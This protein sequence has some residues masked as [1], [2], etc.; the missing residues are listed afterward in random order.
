MFVTMA[1][2]AATTSEPTAVAPW[3]NQRLVSLDAYRGAI[4]L[5]MASGGLGLKKLAENPQFESPV[6]PVL[7]RQVEHVAWTGH[8][9]WDLIQPAFMFMVG[10]SMPYS[11][12]ARW[13]RGDSYRSL[14]W[15]AL[16]RS[17]VLVG[18]GVLL[19]SNGKQQTNFL[20]TNVLAQ[21]GLGYPWL[22]LLW[23]RRPW[24]QVVVLIAVLSGYGWLTARH[25]IAP[26][27]SWSDLGVTAQD[28]ADGAVFTDHRRPWSKHVNL[29]ADVD[30]VLL[31]WFPRAEPFVADRGGYQTLNFVPSLAT[32]ILGLLAGQLLR[33]EFTA[34]RK[35]VVLIV[36]AV[37][38]F[39]VGLALDQ[40]VLPA[41]KR[42]WTPSWALLSGGWVLA[43]LAAFYAVIDVVGWRRWAFP[44]VVVG[45]NSIVMYLMAQLMK[46]WLVATLKTH[47]GTGLFS[48]S[49]EPFLQS[50]GALLA[51]WLICWWL[52][53]Q[54]LFV[55]I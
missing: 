3:A 39:G 25:T 35:L 13:A 1:T 32:M 51:M 41:V 15:H 52:Y 4:M 46:P 28:R 47:L 23:N 5:A 2:I 29:A 17:L 48:G 27:E 20:F 49:Y 31:N 21:I 30:R 12:G 7:A 36:A 33:G 42:I 40:T 14:A 18:L 6:W 55:R 54:R 53:R 34:S 44:L 45:C 26:E 24:L 50:G 10:V 43:M 8:V 9:F 16:V 38:C 11:Y 19:A 22:F 37:V